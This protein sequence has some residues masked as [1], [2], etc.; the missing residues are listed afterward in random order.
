[1][2]AFVKSMMSDATAIGVMAAQRAMASRKDS[3]A[4]ASA[5]AVPAL[6]IHGEDDPVIA[7]GEAEELSRSIP[8]S[9]L[10]T[11]PGAGHLPPVEAPD[12]VTSALRALSLRVAQL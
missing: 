2:V 5:I 12:A 1:M 9:R 10:L 7:R 3:R 6:V 8:G 4:T 11:V